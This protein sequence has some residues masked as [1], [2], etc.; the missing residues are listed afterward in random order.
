MGMSMG[1]LEEAKSLYEKSLEISYPAGY[2]IS[3]W[4]REK[5]DETRRIISNFR[6]LEEAVLYAQKGIKSGFDHRIFDLKK[7]TKLVT[8]KAAQLKEA[9]PAWPSEYLDL[10][11]SPFSEPSSL[12]QIE[13]KLY[14]S[15][16][17]NHIKFYL[18]SVRALGR[19][20]RRVLEI[21]GGYGAL[22]RVFKLAYPRVT[23]VIV[24][25]PESLFYAR[26]FLKCSNGE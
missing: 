19:E 5:Q 3:S 26:C 6:T 10:V 8:Y 4:W 24:D 1:P 2:E 14:S 16:F 21:G 15:I 12:I 20:P 25:L 9:F 17:L 23:Y 11:E 18:E 13:G 7:A 22:A